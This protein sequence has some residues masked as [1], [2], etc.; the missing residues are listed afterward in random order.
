LCNTSLQIGKIKISAFPEYEEWKKFIRALKGPKHEILVAGIF[1][2]IRPVW[3][4]DLETRPKNLKSL[5]LGPYITL[6]FLG[7]LF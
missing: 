6:Y 7:F 1:T 3:V 4:G 2:E 5:C